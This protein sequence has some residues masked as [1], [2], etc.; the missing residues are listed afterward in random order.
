MMRLPSLVQ[1]RHY[2]PRARARAQRCGNGNDFRSRAPG[3]FWRRSRPPNEYNHYLANPGYF[4]QDVQRYQSATTDSIRLFAQEQLKPTAR[5]V[6]Y[7]IPG[8]PDLGPDVADA[9]QPD[10]REEHG[11]GIGECRRAL[12]RECPQGRPGTRA[13][14]PGS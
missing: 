5:V 6:V 9:S 12:A 7:G 3:R 4:P 1:S 2:E 11:R 14:S 8:K 13:E 10:E